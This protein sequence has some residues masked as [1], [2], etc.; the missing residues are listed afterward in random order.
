MKT[1]NQKDAEGNPLHEGDRV[2]GYDYTDNGY[3]RVYG[4]LLISDA[5][6]TFGHWYIESDDG[7]CLMVL[8]FNKVWSARLA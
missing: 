1:T 5:K 2:Y 4:T 8:D 3:Q 6:E 7:E